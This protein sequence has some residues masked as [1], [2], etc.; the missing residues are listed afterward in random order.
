M[1]IHIYT[2]CLSLRTAI[3]SYATADARILQINRTLGRLKLSFSIHLYH[4]RGHANIFGNELADTAASSATTTGT[5]RYSKFSIKSIRT[6]FYDHMYRQWYQ[7]WSNN[8]N[9]TELYQ[10]IPNVENI[11]KYFP[12]PKPLIRIMTAHGRFPY[13][14]HRFNLLP[15]NLCQC[16]HPCTNFLHYLNDCPLT[17][18]MAK[19]LVR[20]HGAPKITQSHY[21]FLLSLKK[22]RAILIRMERTIDLA[23]PDA[24]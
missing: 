15:H 17:R 8:H 24:E 5:I 6:K 4:V 21:P 14:L 9:S 12:P 20:P 1:P 22:N 7:D 11:P 13:Y 3:S 23:T 2:D 19:A 18:N 16:G 10:W